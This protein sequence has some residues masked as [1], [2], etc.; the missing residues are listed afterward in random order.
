MDEVRSLLDTDVED[1]TKREY[2]RLKKKIYSI[3]SE[4]I[5]GKLTG[6]NTDIIKCTHEGVESGPY[7]DITNNTGYEGIVESGFEIYYYREKGYH[8]S[9]IYYV[10]DEEFNVRIKSLTPITM[11]DILHN[12]LFNKFGY[13]GRQD[14]LTQIQLFQRAGIYKEEF[15]TPTQQIEGSGVY[16][17]EYGSFYFKNGYRHYVRI[18]EVVVLSI[19]YTPIEEEHLHE[20]YGEMLKS[21]YAN[22]EDDVDSDD[23]MAQEK[24]EQDV[25]DGYV[26]DYADD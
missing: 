6:T 17:D 21:T 20:G 15:T 16:K 14:M 12:P 4:A 1:L 10:G 11:L 7:R 9:V 22:Y 24:V 8:H 19:P 26:D 18:K 13:E 25:N 2:K 5:M 23:F 3:I